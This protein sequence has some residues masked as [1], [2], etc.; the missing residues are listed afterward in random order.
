LEAVSQY[1]EIVDG[2]RLGDERAIAD[3]HALL[4]RSAKP[5]IQQRLGP[6]DAEDRLRDSFILVLR[7]IRDGKINQADHLIGYIFTVVRRQITR[8]AVLTAHRRNQQ[9][10]VDENAQYV[11]AQ[12]LDV[13]GNLMRNEQCRNL[14]N[15]L[16]RL[17]PKDRE[18][19]TRFY[20]R[21]Q[22]KE[23]VCE[24]MR[25]TATQFRLVKN[26]AKTHFAELHRLVELAA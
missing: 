10:T 26:R 11:N 5:Y 19:L 21:E 24:Q 2:V 6:Q 22:A 16:A 8:C 3:L 13:E 4:V 15:L 23:V 14:R 7:A 1:V 20:L 12:V 25:L 18:V 17:R 9:V